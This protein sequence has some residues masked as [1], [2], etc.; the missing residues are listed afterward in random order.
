MKVFQLITVIAVLFCWPMKIAAPSFAHL[1][2]SRYAG[3]GILTI[4]NV[5]THEFASIKYKD[6]AGNY[7]NSGIDEINNIL[8]C[9]LT[10][11]EKEMSLKLIE[12]VDDI[13]DHF[14]KGYIEVISGYRSPVLNSGLRRAGH[15]V[16]LK[17]LHMEGLAMDIKI[18]GVSFSAIR[19]YAKSLKAGGVGYYPNQFVHVDTGRVR[20]W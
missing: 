18:P 9:R 3:D 20:Y 12:L 8:R 11:I 1:N 6:N 7:L 13:E 10:G 15:K 17:S 14:G 19:N 2:V 16:A 4:Y 5:H